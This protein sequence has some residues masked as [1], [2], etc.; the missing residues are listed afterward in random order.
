MGMMREELQ[1]SMK[2]S[3][4]KQEN[5]MER[6]NLLIGTGDFLLEKNS[7]GSSLS[8]LLNIGEETEA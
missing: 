1:A 3:W 6:L 7:K 5:Y 4:N 8:S 2:Q